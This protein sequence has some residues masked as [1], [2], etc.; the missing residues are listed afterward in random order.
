MDFS[1]EQNDLLSMALSVI[2][3]GIIGSEREFKNKSTGFRTIVLICLGS[4]LFTIVSQYGQG[5]DGRI[6]ANIITGIGFIGAGVI[7]K[8]KLS[9]LGLTT[10]AVIWTT[11]AIGMAV[12]IGYYGIA[13]VFTIVTFVVLSF[14]TNVETLIEGL[15]KN[16]TVNINFRDADC[17][18]LAELQE[19]I[20]SG[21]LKSKIVQI[22]KRDGKLNAVLL[23]AGEKEDMTRLHEIMMQMEE[24]TDFY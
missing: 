16:K 22:S 7:F 8:D 23:I 20:R 17:S 6:A 3:G 12:G 18:R 24:I 4:T 15:R 11:A 2:C 10:A 21:N 9:V 5:S 14:I 19:K 13:I 1:I